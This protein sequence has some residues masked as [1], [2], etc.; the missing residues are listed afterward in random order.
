MQSNWY[1]FPLANMDYSTTSSAS[2]SFPLQ[3][4]PSLSAPPSRSSHGN[5]RSQETLPTVQTSSSG[6]DINLEGS[7]AR[8]L[9]PSTNSKESNCTENKK[10][11]LLRVAR[12]P[13]RPKN[14]SSESSCHKKFFFNDLDEF[15]NGFESWMKNQFK[16]PLFCW[17]SFELEN[18][19]RKEKLPNKEDLMEELEFVWDA[20]QSDRAAFFL[21]PKQVGAF[22]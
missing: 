17:D 9:L 11:Y 20:Y 19:L 22:A 6:L 10:K 18:P 1:D 5:S 2:C 16:D 8:S 3:T 13:A 12:N 7:P 15:K 14:S 4:T 21:V